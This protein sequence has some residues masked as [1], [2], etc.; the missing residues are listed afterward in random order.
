MSFRND[1]KASYGLP[2]G[3]ASEG[4]EAL[5]ITTSSAKLEA[6][7]PLAGRTRLIV[8][9]TDG[10]IF[11]GKVTG[12]TAASGLVLKQDAW[13]ELEGGT[14][15]WAISAGAVDVRVFEVLD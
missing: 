2:G 12:V 4:P 1:R 7:S 15:W 8:V 9:P 6:A 13:L 11:I 3:S 10:D 5:S 14:T